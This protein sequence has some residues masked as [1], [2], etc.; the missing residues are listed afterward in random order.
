MR[1][2]AL[3]TSREDLLFRRAVICAG[4]RSHRLRGPDV[5]YVQHNWPARLF[6]SP[7]HCRTVVVRFAG[8]ADKDRQTPRAP[9][10][11]SDP[12]PAARHKIPVA[13]STFKYQFGQK[14]ACE[15][16]FPA[17]HRDKR[18]QFRPRT[19]GCKLD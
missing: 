3:I 10:V 8:T 9:G 1:S 14:S 19:R 7:A 17:L 4:P 2:T 15:A 13:M 12:G 5:A 11:S 18:R 16:Y 6:H